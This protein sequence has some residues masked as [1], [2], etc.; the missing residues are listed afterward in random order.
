MWRFRQTDAGQYYW[1]NPKKLMT[2]AVFP[3]L[4][5]LDKSIKLFRKVLVKEICG[6][7]LKKNILGDV[8]RFFKVDNEIKAFEAI[9]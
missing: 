3:Y 1:I 6:L 8:M 2:S 9:H 5:E 7:T 4:N